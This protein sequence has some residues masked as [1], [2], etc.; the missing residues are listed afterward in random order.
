MRCITKRTERKK[1]KQESKNA[2]E[3]KRK[4]TKW[5]TRS[6]YVQEKHPAQC[7]PTQQQRPQPNPDK[8]ALSKHR[9]QVEQIAD[10][11]ST[12][13]SSS[14]RS[15]ASPN[16]CTCSRPRLVITRPHHGMEG[17]PIASLGRLQT[18]THH[19]V[20]AHVVEGVLLKHT[21]LLGALQ[22]LL[23]RQ[24]KQVLQSVCTMNAPHISASK[25]TKIPS[26]SSSPFSY[27][28]ASKNFV[29]PPSAIMR[30]TLM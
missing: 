4:H 24:L 21:A 15:G 16:S 13:P 29:V 1:R 17:R 27:T 22:V 3:K 2:G 18:Q 11:L 10:L 20:G 5:N 19:M 28:A 14:C 26:Q 8:V 12:H 25:R 30:C 23:L 9:I 7:S 6:C